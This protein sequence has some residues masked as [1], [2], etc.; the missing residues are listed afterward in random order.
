[1]PEA[2][3]AGFVCANPRCA[4]AG[5]LIRPRNYPMPGWTGAVVTK[6]NEVVCMNCSAMMEV[7]AAIQSGSYNSLYLSS[8][9]GKYLVTNFTGVIRMPVTDIL[10]GTVYRFA[11]FDGNDWEGVVPSSDSERM[12]ARRATAKPLRPA[13]SNYWHP[14]AY[15][16]MGRVGP[17]KNEIH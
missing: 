12:F 6:T 17:S 13:L 1:M 10:P 5:Y 11:A 4:E 14:V 16:R 8:V 3:V 9:D 2:K 7:V 15:V